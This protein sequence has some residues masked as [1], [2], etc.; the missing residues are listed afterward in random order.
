MYDKRLR[1]TKRAYSLCTDEQFS[2]G[3]SAGE[4]LGLGNFESPNT[5]QANPGDLIEIDRK[6][7]TH[8][9]LCIGDESERREEGGDEIKGRNLQVVYVTGEN[10]EAFCT[11]R[12]KQSS[13]K[14]V[15]TWG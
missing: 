3:I 10:S 5:L 14:E 9:A 8:W 2:A 6:L 12:V 13:L 11:A 1:S 4:V 7:Y 15:S